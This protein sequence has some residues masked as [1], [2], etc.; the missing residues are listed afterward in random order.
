MKITP[1]TLAKIQDVLSSC[2]FGTED[3]SKLTE[4]AGL[5][6]LFGIKALKLTSGSSRS[7]SLLTQERINYL[8]RYV[9]AGYNQVPR[10]LDLVAKKSEE[11]L[12]KQVDHILYADQPMKVAKIILQLSDDDS[13]IMNAQATALINNIDLFAAACCLKMIADSKKYT[14]PAF[15]WEAYQEKIY[16]STSPY[17][18]VTAVA[19]LLHT[20][21]VQSWIPDTLKLY[22]DKALQHA[23]PL[24]MACV[25][26]IM[27]E[28][29]VLSDV[30]LNEMFN[31]VSPLAS[32][33]TWEVLA[34]LELSAEHRARVLTHEQP[35]A[36]A[37]AL[38]DI[39]QHHPEL[40]DELAD[41]ILNTH[42][43]GFDLRITG[44]A[45]KE[46]AGPDY[47]LTECPLTVQRREALKILSH[48]SKKLKLQV[49]R[50]PAPFEIATVLIKLYKTKRA[51]YSSLKEAFLTAICPLGAMQT[52]NSEYL[53]IE[54]SDRV[55]I[56]THPYPY[57]FAQAL[58]DFRKISPEFY[59][60][61]K[62]LISSPI[63]LYKKLEKEGEGSLY[64]YTH[65]PL[66]VSALLVRLHRS[67]P[68]LLDRVREEAIRLG[69]ENAL[70]FLAVLAGVRASIPDFAEVGKLAE[71]ETLINKLLPL[72]G[73]G[74]ILF[75]LG[76]FGNL[77]QTV[78]DDI[79]AHPEKLP[80]IDA[81][82]DLY[83]S[84]ELEWAES[85]RGHDQSIKHVEFL[86]NE[87]LI[88]FFKK[89]ESLKVANM[90]D[91]CTDSAHMNLSFIPQ[92]IYDACDEA[93]RAGLDKEAAVSQVIAKLTEVVFRGGPID[94]L[95]EA[96]LDKARMRRGMKAS[97][98]ATT[99][100]AVFGAAGAA[101][102]FGVRADVTVANAG[103][104]REHKVREAPG[105][106]G[107]QLKSKSA[108][109]LRRRIGGD[110]AACDDDD[111]A[112]RTGL[113]VA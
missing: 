72:I 94:P 53:V 75:K 40:L 31:Q 99:A 77:K 33:R 16:K 96:A 69:E 19:L 45:L 27:A 26:H 85:L 93:I 37:M 13:I 80:I 43:S 11:S 9:A 52:L 68:S 39:K 46:E 25:I 3:V 54:E 32:I 5:L 2:G 35:L 22:L 62:V 56:I 71:T 86:M 91:T 4:S 111:A 41:E 49:F 79:F 63:A 21:K 47:K 50:H 38:A 66:L 61:N 82:M 108:D 34:K 58:M 57:S 100:Q 109:G 67:S 44:L 83:A 17:H 106:T 78:L 98:P 76:M 104:G 60:A 6:L 29:G 70:Y 28:T 97:S 84:P 102:G 14:N 110:A 10:A 64:S 18:S 59:E 107:V 88:S 105:A 23:K 24:S 7:D 48:A 81:F 101:A 51:L 30:T 55:A 113:V 90:V 8:I 12:R 87:R 73:S 65:T 1:V 92:D 95:P 89:I 74:H 42:F 20:A 15:K 112:E 103:A 36:A